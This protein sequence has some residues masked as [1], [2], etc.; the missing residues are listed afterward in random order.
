VVDG[1]TLENAAWYYKETYDA[2]KNIEGF[3]AFC[4]LLS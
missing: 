4:E 1:Q 2:A 3:V